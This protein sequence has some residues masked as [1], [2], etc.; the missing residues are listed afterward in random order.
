MSTLIDEQKPRSPFA[1]V[2]EWYRD[3]A[4]RASELSC[5]ADEEIARMA[6]DV[7][8]TPTE[9]RQLARHGSG[10]ANLLHQRLAALELDQRE[11]ARQ[12]PQTL[13]DLQRVCSLCQFHRR[14]ARD[15]AHNAADPAWKDYCPNAATLIALNAEPW[16]ARAEW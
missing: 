15:L 6:G 14:C 3:W 8:L 13:H 5:C 10:A 7:G 16:P 12:E 9:L 11:V 2:K 4:Q 1:A